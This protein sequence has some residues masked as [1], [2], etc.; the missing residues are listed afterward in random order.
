MHEA[1]L[2]EEMIFACTEATGN[3]NTAI[4]GVR[5]ICKWFGG[6]LVYIPRTKIEGTKNSEK[7]RS[8]LYDAVGEKDAEKMLKHL[9][10]FFGGVQLYIPIEQRA[11]KKEIAEEIY[12]Q[13]DGTQDSMR[14]LCREYGISFAQVYRLWSKG[15]T[16]RVKQL[17]IAKKN[18]SGKISGDSLAGKY[19]VI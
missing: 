3:R 5:A 1:N 19:G 17:S 2:V 9:I 12:A 6:Q 13:Y 15:Q 18:P 7:M 4:R 16:T 14:N 11:F 10:T 8:I